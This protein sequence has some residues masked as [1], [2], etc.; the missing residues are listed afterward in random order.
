VP[1]TRRGGVGADAKV[2][3]TLSLSDPDVKQ[4]ARHIDD[5][6]RRPTQTFPSWLGK[7]VPGGRP[8]QPLHRTWD[9]DEIAKSRRAANL[10]CDDVWGSYDGDILNCDEYPFATTREG[11]GRGDKRYSARLIDAGDNQE[12]GRTLQKTFTLNRLLDGDPFY[13]SIRP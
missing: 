4:A 12:S 11:A 10:I 13:V 1:G 9:E 3:Y 6:L 2:Y 5:A 8:D 7:S